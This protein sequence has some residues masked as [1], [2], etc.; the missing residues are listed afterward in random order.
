MKNATIDY[1][2]KEVTYAYF[3]LQD[4]ILINLDLFLI[5]SNLLI[6]LISSLFV[7]L[8]LNLKKVKSTFW[9]WLW[10]WIKKIFYKILNFFSKLIDDIKSNKI[11]NDIKSNKIIIVIVIVIVLLL[12]IGASVYY[13]YF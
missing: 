12:A 8:T 5:D 9:S 3:Y 13:F 10:T 11:I 6:F 2:S 1:V 4:Q 7:I